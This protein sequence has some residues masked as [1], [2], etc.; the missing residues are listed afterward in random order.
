MGKLVYLM[1]VSLDGYVET[2]EHSLDWSH[3]DEEIH[4]WFSDQSRGTAAFLYGRRLYETM[5]AY[6][7]YSESDPN[8]TDYMLEFGRIWRRT[9][10]LV[11][12]STRASV[13]GNSRLIRGDPI[14]ELP[15]IRAEFDGELS[16]GGPTL[17]AAFV[18]AG[19]VDTFRLV[20]HPAILG[21]GTPFFPSLEQPL[22]LRLADSRRF[23][24]GAYFLGYDRI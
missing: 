6:W 19:L 12:S 13:E 2:P 7:P 23:A 24:S 21:A 8:A 18:R 17:A 4:T 22:R 15:R 3:V 16:V 20:V 11:F 5:A 10:K 9:P 1:N 14:E